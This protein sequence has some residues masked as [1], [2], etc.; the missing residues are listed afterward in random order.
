[1]ASEQFSLG[2]GLQGTTHATSCTGLGS[3][4]ISQQPCM[5]P[6]RDD[7]DWLFQ[8]MFDEYFNP[9]TIAVSPVQ[10]AAAPRAK[11]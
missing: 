4:P 6:I 10:E 9:P 2:P 3:N 1:M 5:P 7:W 8:P 11:V